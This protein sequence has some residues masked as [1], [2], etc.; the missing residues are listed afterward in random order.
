MHVKDT[1]VQFQ[2]LGKYIQHKDGLQWIVQAV[3][4]CLNPGEVT[5]LVGPSGC[6]KTTLLCLLSGLLSPSKGSVQIF[7]HDIFS[8]SEDEKTLFRRQKMGFVF[9]NYN[10]IPSLQ[11]QENVA[12][13][14]LA[15]HIERGKALQKA[16]DML[17]KL[18]LQAQI[19]QL[20]AQLS[21]GQQQR[22]AIARALIH[23]P[24]FLVCDEPTAALDEASGKATMTLLTH[25][26]KAHG[27]VTLIV[28]HDP[29]IYHYGDQILTMEEGKFIKPPSSNTEREVHVI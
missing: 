14:L 15:D 12:I 26:T 11:A 22:I 8:M 16:Q 5:L 1:T 20:P 17:Q 25:H 24:K 9:Q 13:P 18:G 7:G 27:C 23:Q 2:D 29:R 28:T 21:G 10:L 19:Q 3:S 6:G 4:G